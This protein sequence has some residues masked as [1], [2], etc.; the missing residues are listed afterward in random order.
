LGITSPSRIDG[1]ITAFDLQAKTATKSNEHHAQRIEVGELIHGL[2][3][4]R[5]VE[6]G[7]GAKY[8]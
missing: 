5:C 4:S 7:A 2:Q 6:L 8:A 1:V 3:P